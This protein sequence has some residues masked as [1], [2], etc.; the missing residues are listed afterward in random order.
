[1]VEI[2]MAC[3]WLFQES[4]ITAPCITDLAS[5]LPPWSFPKIQ[6]LAFDFFRSPNLSP[7]PFVANQ[8]RGVV[9]FNNPPPSLG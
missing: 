2:E 1:M 4:Q 9:L 3:F 8:S 6:R 7:K 5:G